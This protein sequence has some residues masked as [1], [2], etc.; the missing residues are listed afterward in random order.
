MIFGLKGKIPVQELP[1][2]FYNGNLFG[3]DKAD[4]EGTMEESE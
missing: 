3:N 2:C 1:G 4:A